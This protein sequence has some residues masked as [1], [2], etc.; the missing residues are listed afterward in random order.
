MRSHNP[1]LCVVIVYGGLRG[2]TSPAHQGYNPLNLAL[3]MMASPEREKPR[4]L[5]QHTPPERE[6]NFVNVLRKDLTLPIEKILRK[7]GSG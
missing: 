4:S 2:A 7:R 1:L 5:Q 3:Q 6:K